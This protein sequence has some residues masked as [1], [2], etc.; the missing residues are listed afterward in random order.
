MRLPLLSLAI[1]LIVPCMSLG[2][3][4][5]NEIQSSNH[6]SAYDDDGDAPDWIELLN[7]G[8]D[9]VN[10][11]GWG[12]SDRLDDPFRWTFPSVEL[13]AGERLVVWCS[14]KD[15]NG[16][17]AGLSADSPDDIPG[18][19]LWLRAEGE[20]YADG[21]S[22]ATWTDL[23]GHGNHGA[24][25][26]NASRPEFRAGAV[27]GKPA[28]GF[29]KV[30]GQEFRLPV[31]SFDGL[32]NLNNFT[33]FSVGSWTG[34]EG[35]SGFFGAWHSSGGATPTHLEVGGDEAVSFRAGDM[36]RIEVTDVVRGGEWSVFSATLAGTQDSPLARLFKDGSL[37]GSRAESPG[38]IPLE[39][40][41]RMAVG[42]SQDDHHLDGEVAEVLLYNRPLDAAELAFLNVYL[43]TRYALP[44][45]SLPLIPQ[46]H[47]SFSIDSGGEALVLTRPGGETEDL[48]PAV[49]IPQDASY[50]R[51]P[52]GGSPLAYFATPTPGAP[53]A[54]ESYG[55]PLARPV[56]SEP[57]GF[58]TSSFLLAI[59]HPDLGATIR[60]TTDGSD[61][62]PTHGTVYT[63]PVP[64]NKTTVVRAAA[65]KPGALPYR[66]VAT[67]S[68]LFLD[69]IVDQTAAVPPGY[70]ADW[71]GFAEISYAISP[72]I[73]SRPGYESKMKAALESFPSL[74]IS[75]AP[76]D[77]FGV[78]G[79]YSNPRRHGYEKVA[80]AEW[81][82]PDGSIDVQVDA[83]LRI[84]GGASRYMDRTPKKSLRLSFRGIY[85]EDRLKVP[86]LG[87]L[88]TLPSFDTIILRGEYNN[89]WLAT[90]SSGRDRGTNMRDEFLRNTQ[91]LMSGQASRGNHVHLYINGLYWGVYNPCEAPDA[92]FAANLFGGDSEEYDAVNHD[93]VKDGDNI[94]WEAMRAIAEAGLSSPEQYAAIQQ[95][96]DVDQFIDYMMVNIYGANQDWPDNNWAATRRRQ[97]GA[98]YKF[99]M[100]DGEKAME[101]ENSN[102]TN[103]PRSS[104]NYDNP[105]VIYMALRDNAEFRL[106][107][108]DHVHRHCFNGGVLAADVVAQRYAAHAALVEA[109]VF[110][111]EAR[112][113]AYRN[114]IFDLDGPSPIYSLDPHWLAER[115]RL[116]D[117]YFP[118]RT[119]FV[120]EEFREEDLYPSI[121][122]PVFSQHGGQLTAGQTVT[123]TANGGTI[124]Y[125]LDGSDPRVEITGAVSPTAMAYAAPLVLSGHKTLKARVVNGGEWSALN[126]ADF[127]TM[128][129]ES[130][131]KPAGSGDWTLNSNW[132]PSPYPNGAG[133]SAL[134]H[135]PVGGDRN[136]NLRAPVTVG[137]LRFDETGNLF[138][139]RLRDQLTGKTLTFNGGGA[140]ALL[141]VDGDGSGYVELEVIAGTHLA[142]DLEVA[143]N[144]PGGDPEHGALRL[145]ETWSGSGGIHKSGP[146]VLSLTGDGKDFTGGL[147]VREGV[148]QVS[149]PACPAL[150]SSVSVAAGGQLRLTS[151]SSPG[152]P[153]LYGF[154]VP[155]QIAGSGRGA[156]I[157]D[158]GGF[159]KTGALRYDPGS[160][161][162]H[163]VLPVPVRLNA[164]AGIHVDGS[165]NRLELTA[166]IDSGLLDPAALTLTKSGGGALHLHA[167]NE[168]FTGAMVISNGSLEISGALGS[169]V[170]IS[171]DGVLTGYGQTG[172]LSGSGTLRLDRQILAAPSFSGGA[173]SVVIG[174]EGSPDYLQASD[175]G[176]GLLRVDALAVPPSV[177]RIYLTGSGSVFRGV[178]FAPFPVD[179]AAAMH[180]SVTEVYQPD[181]GGWL[182]APGAQ[183][184]TVP[185]IADFGS[186]PVMGHVVEVRLDAAPASIDAWKLLAFPDAGDRN[187]P[188]VGGLEANPQNDGIP[189]LLRYA[190]GIGPGDDPHA[191][192]PQLELPG[193]RAEF[194]F[195]FDPGRD[196]I[197][198]LVEATSDPADWA[199]A[200]V[201][202]DSRSDY[203]LRLE[204]GWLVIED[205]L[206]APVRFYRLRVF[207]R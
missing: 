125:T 194:R 54:L 48:V 156:A 122:A 118:G 68:Y 105:A 158:G 42:N 203:P 93:G 157:P 165:E 137:N 132:T 169:P 184:V 55:P 53:N 201:L 26:S 171:S 196:D 115:D 45:A 109:G 7:T 129:P 180:A 104:F 130:V 77:M 82:T 92:A 173:L 200:E 13:T 206:S 15:R 25:P 39:D 89:S 97:P 96:L 185:E 148:V 98:G 159:G 190:L 147:E 71:D 84:H 94:A 83:G 179:L 110:G 43:G 167:S 187:D 52:D 35:T 61:P 11:A 69:D 51:S 114:E 124:Y 111:E 80:S 151:G 177:C 75:I 134:I 65:F 78:E 178:L 103:P 207:V 164:S 101:S 37:I 86:V 30:A 72:T 155:I 34:G 136:V 128:L 18:L 117:D 162:N 56:L 113:G 81:I 202:F 154:G 144:H 33:V 16:T 24:A 41:D 47:T 3:V 22:A 63:S 79:I 70:P 138:R 106:R 121:D 66:A 59:T 199:N 204:D 182:L 60:Y 174:E 126:E 36:N 73:A 188:L 49:A 149:E 112:W 175:S 193:D 120:V 141:Q 135:A 116:L 27:N 189:N 150:V 20:G 183:V 88:G 108:A 57:H 153:R 14:G 85:G 62:S 192:L 102:R 195:P 172:P 74:V 31:S 186:G 191:L 46:I 67:Q 197:A 4:V 163:A 99:W 2:G 44:G 23:S 6:A 10:L 119:D 29:T 176:N 17:G 166:P 1:G 90:V 91:A 170:S 21:Q 12:L 160:G 40:L 131:F 145:R 95:Y 19:V 58:K 28:F 76:D 143:V 123:I 140:D 168:T 127:H 198:C 142:S 181:G 5:I 139:N 161:E 146:G 205:L 133:E 9:P 87:D 152:V 100:W 38:L 64:V 107:F 8:P 50:G 32:T